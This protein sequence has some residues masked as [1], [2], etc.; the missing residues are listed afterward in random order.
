MIVRLTE[1]QIEY[2][3]QCLSLALQQ[4]GVAIVDDVAAINSALLKAEPEKKSRRKESGD[5]GAS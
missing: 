1:Q 4:H 5:V 2:L 3:R